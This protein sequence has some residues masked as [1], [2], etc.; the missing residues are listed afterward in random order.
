V[1]NGRVY[2]DATPQGDPIEPGSVGT[3]ADG[4]W[5]WFDVVDPTV[6]DLSTLQ[7]ELGS[8]PL[9]VEDS[10]HRQQRPKVELYAYGMNFEGMPRAASVGRLPDGARDDGGGVDGALRGVQEER[11]ALVRRQA[12][13]A[14]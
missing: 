6:V 11:L 12:C 14:R 7:T 4:D 9:A 2:R 8:H 13:A 5:C 10:R 1:I 3:L